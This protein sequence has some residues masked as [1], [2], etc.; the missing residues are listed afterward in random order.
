MTI[1]TIAGARKY[2]IDPNNSCIVQV[3][4]KAGARWVTYATRDSAKE[5]K[6][7]VLILARG[8]EKER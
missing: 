6:E 3:Q 5:A 2:R 4:Y 1:E 7:L 8:E